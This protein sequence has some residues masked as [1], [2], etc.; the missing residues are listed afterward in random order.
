MNGM[1]FFL[2]LEAV[3]FRASGLQFRALRALQVV[4]CAFLDVPHAVNVGLIKI[5]PFMRWTSSL[6]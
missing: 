3:T 2:G 4:V 5:H 6:A 1:D